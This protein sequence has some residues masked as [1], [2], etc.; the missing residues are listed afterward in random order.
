MTDVEVRIAIG[1]TYTSDLTIE[2][3]Y[4][5]T[6]IMLIS[7]EGL[8]GDNIDVTVR[9]VSYFSSYVFECVHN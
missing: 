5:G 9:F 8:A 1:H 4:D 6:T 7:R 2:L 3:E